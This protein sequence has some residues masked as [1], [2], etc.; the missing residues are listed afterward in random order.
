M[1]RREGGV[2]TAR[3]IKLPQPCDFFLFFFAFC[4]EAQ[5]RNDVAKPTQFLFDIEMKILIQ[6]SLLLLLLFHKRSDVSNYANKKTET[7]QP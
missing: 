3:A 5:D 7:E 2:R 6:T 1:M 4:R